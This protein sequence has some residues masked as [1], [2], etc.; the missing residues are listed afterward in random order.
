MTIIY[1][2]KL[3]KFALKHAS[4]GKSLNVWK[5]VVERATWTKDTDVLKDFPRAK[6]I[7]GSRARFKITGNKYRLIVELDYE[8]GIAEIRFIGTHSQYDEI[9]AETI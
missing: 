1:L 5:T 2:L 9:D 3:E 4:A 7:K 6:I 8:D